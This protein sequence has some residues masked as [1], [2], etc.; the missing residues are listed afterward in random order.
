M[1]HLRKRHL[2]AL[3][4]IFSMSM[5]NDAVDPGLKVQL[6]QTGLNYAASVAVDILTVQVQQ[7]SLPDQSGTADIKVGKVDYEFKNMKVTS[8]QKP[9]T[10]LTVNTGSG[11]SWSVSGASLSV[12]GDWHYKYK[13]GFIKIS[14]SGSFDVDVSGLTASVAVTLG[15]S[16]TGEPTI[17]STGCDCNINDLSIHLHG[18]A[19]W[20]YDL[21]I[22]S[23]SHP[24]RRN[25]QSKLC[26][27]ARKAVDED[28]AR[29]LS[30]LK[31]QVVI[32]HQWLLDY[33]LVTG[34]TFGT[35]YFE[36]YHKGEFFFAAE[37]TEAPFKPASLP[38]QVSSDHM[39]TFWI[40]DYVLNTAGYVLHQRKILS[41]NLTQK[42]LPGDEKSFL[43]TTCCAACSC[44]GKF[45]PQVAKSFPE[46]YV[47]AWMST[48]E[49]PT[50]NIDPTSIF[51]NF[52]GTIILS[53]RLSNGSLAHLFEMKI[54]AKI[55]ILPSFDGS[56]LRASVSSISEVI[57][58]VESSIGPVSPEV[59]KFFFDFAKKAFIIPQLN[60]VG[61]KGFPIPRI[62]HVRF[63]NTD[64]QLMSNCVCL[65]TDVE[66]NPNTLYFEPRI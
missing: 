19:S 41:Y 32:D 9:S 46:A 44:I 14:D 49:P 4:F 31:V 3:L 66:Y 27:T 24:L 23:V 25:I 22:G 5:L 15:A 64:I 47:E 37:P 38:S 7:A 63:S 45:L 28:A 36:S 11:L 48:S 62:D 61:A 65:K 26:D 42:D 57:S 52:T 55:V 40:S 51:G 60:A 39:A 1:A 54:T 20:L 10:S 50:I 29:E 18:G 21:F 59:I 13:A 16:Q 8:F 43:N 2:V 35:G 12:H 17:H 58:I 34:P 6:S 30:T 33:R 56:T 53:A